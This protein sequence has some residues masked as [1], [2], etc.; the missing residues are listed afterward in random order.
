MDVTAKVRCALKTVYGEGDSKHAR[1]HFV[2]DYVGKQGNHINEEW[3]LATPS[4]SLE[5]MLNGKVADQFETDKS[6]TL[7]FSESE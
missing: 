3:S 4:L 7:T 6:Y 2:A 1:V 5:M